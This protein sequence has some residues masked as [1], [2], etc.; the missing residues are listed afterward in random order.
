[1]AKTQDTYMEPTVIVKDGWT[2]RVYRPIL[3]EEER[4]RRMKL[5]HDAAANLLK[6]CMK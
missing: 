4:A 6:G 2:I 5:L 1:M 3:T